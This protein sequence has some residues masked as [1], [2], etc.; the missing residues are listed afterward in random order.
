ME[1]EIKYPV[2]INK[3]LAFQKICA[4]READ[5]LIVQGKVKINGRKAVLGEKVNEKDK[6]SVESNIKKFIYLA[7]NKPRGVITHS[8][9]EGEKAIKDIIN[10]EKDVFPLGRLDKDSSGLIILT[11]DGRITDRLLNPKYEHE[12][13]YIVKIKGSI[14]ESFLKKMANGIKLDDGYITKECEVQKISNN[15]FSIILTEGKKH[16][17][18]RMCDKLG[19]VISDLKRVRVM[20]IKL[21]SLVEGDYREIKGTELSDFLQLLEL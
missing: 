9:Q 21:Q 6:V 17:I 18:R 13:E 3:Y 20:N 1:E 10:L 2:R 15:R 7:L 11:N 19:Q 8:P 14:T 16:Q 12:K 5:E 4:R